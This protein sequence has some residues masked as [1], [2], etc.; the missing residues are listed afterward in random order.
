MSALRNSGATAP[1][2][3]MTPSYT[4]NV[5]FLEFGVSAGDVSIPH[6][7]TTTLFN[8]AGS[9]TLPVPDWANE[10][11][12][13]AVGGGGGGHQGATYGVSGCGGDSGTWSL[14]SWTRGTHY[15]GS[16]SIGVT[17]PAAAAG[18]GGNGHNGG[19]VV[20]TLGANTLTALGGAGSTAISGGGINQAGDSPGN[21]TLDGVTYVG[22]GA[23]STPGGDGAAPGGG[24][25]GGNFVSFQAG[26]DGAVGSAWVRFKQ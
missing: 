9:N 23:Q 3:T 16:P 4:T 13:I 2:S 26:G 21:Q 8:L 1:P 19:N 5:P 10:I 7:P 15:S 12:V 20:V 6:T 17:V 24:G 22:G 14:T 18:G 25:A 11:Q